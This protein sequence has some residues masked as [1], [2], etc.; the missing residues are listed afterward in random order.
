MVPC[1]LHQTR[2]AKGMT[3]A[4]GNE[5]TEKMSIWEAPYIHFQTGNTRSAEMG[6]NSLYTFKRRAA[7]NT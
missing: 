2:A 3:Q 6:E 1:S 5:G 4:P 7:I